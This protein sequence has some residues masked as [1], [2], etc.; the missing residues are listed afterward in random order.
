MAD[1]RFLRKKQ[2]DMFGEHRLLFIKDGIRHY[3]CK[4]SWVCGWYWGM[5]YIT[6]YTNEKNPK[7]SRDISSLTHLPSYWSLFS[8]CVNTVFKTKKEMYKFIDLMKLAYKKKEE[9]ESAYR[10][11]EDLYLNLKISLE[12]TLDEAWDILK[13]K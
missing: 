8:N 11:D 4:H 7:R 13:P 10:S 12:K 2:V 3:L 1:R 5:G 6:T 9:M